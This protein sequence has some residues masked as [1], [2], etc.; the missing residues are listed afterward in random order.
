MKIGKVLKRIFIPFYW[1]FEVVE[2]N[3]SI[4]YTS[5]E[6]N[7]ELRWAYGIFLAFYIAIRLGLGI[8][9]AN[10]Y[11]KCRIKSIADVIVTPMYALGCNL[12]KDRFDVRLN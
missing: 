2:Y 3:K 12:G 4:Y 8:F 11:G 1:Y 9:Q 7:V 6:K 10:D 5:D